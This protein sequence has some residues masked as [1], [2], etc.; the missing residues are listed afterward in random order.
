MKLGGCMGATPLLPVVRYPVYTGTR[1]T[2][3]GVWYP[4]PGTGIHIHLLQFHFYL[5][6]GGLLTNPYKNNFT[7]NAVQK[8]SDVGFHSYL[9]R[10]FPE[11]KLYGV[12]MDYYGWC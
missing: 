2:V 9:K 3:P 4:V 6:R 1:C 11:G 8:V 10:G 5:K 7:F 12:P